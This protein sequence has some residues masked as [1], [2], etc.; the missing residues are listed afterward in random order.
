MQLIQENTFFITE[1]LDKW[2]IKYSEKY[3]RFHQPHVHTFSSQARMT[4][5]C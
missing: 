4:F 2:S 1:A 5:S 3:F